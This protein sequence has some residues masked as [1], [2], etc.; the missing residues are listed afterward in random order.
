VTTTPV[1]DQVAG[2]AVVRIL[3]MM[4][5]AEILKIKSKRRRRRSE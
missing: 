5:E 3:N 1:V 2:G 4:K